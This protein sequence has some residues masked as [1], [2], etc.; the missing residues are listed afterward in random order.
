MCENYENTDKKNIMYIFNDRGWGGAGQSL[1]DI[2]REI[3]KEINP[4]VVVRDDV[5]VEEKFRELGICCYKIHFTT[6]YIQIGKSDEMKKRMTLQQEYEA[7]LQLLPIIKK[8]KIQMIHINSSVSNFAAIA[9]LM[10]QI[11]YIWHIRELL[12]EQFGYEFINEELKKFLYARA[13]ALVTISDYVQKRYEERYGISTTKIYNGFDI[14]KY[15]LELKEREGFNHLFLAAAMIT[16]EKGQW[17][18]ICAVESLVERGYANVKVIIV[19][20]GNPSYIWALKK[21]ITKRGLEENIS[22]LPFQ[23]NLSELRKQVSYAITSSQNEALGRVTIEA[24]LAGNVVIGAK[25]GGTLE[26]VGE[27]EERGFLYELHNSEDLANTM[28]RAIQYSKELKSMMRR[29]AQIY[30]ESTFDSRKYCKGLLKLYNEKIASYA[31]KNTENFLIELKEYCKGETD[32][33]DG[34][35]KSNDVPFKKRAL[36]L[37]PVLKWLE[38]KQ[39]GHSLEE[40]FL[41]NHIYSVAIYGMGLLGC[42]LYDELEKSKI[43]IKYLLDK[44]PRGM[45]KALEFASLDG[46]KLK[47]DAVVVTVVSEEQQIIDEIYKKG[48]KK[49]I[50]LNEI[51]DSF[52]PI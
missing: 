26:V 47:I 14:K 20:D 10:A 45:E 7:A 9:A 24:M 32:F 22:I 37:S 18:I 25:S 39:K 34:I 35:N 11:P 3:R 19:G 2:L 12:E 31:P 28:I 1:L 49:I 13:E 6:D 44:N 23:D 38:I 21:Y 42:R 17:D 8:E 52:N 43:R 27:M 16:P 15:K 46:E 33:E 36:L 30:A 5:S 29:K 50:G 40:Y 51:L 48:Y 41:K 4:I